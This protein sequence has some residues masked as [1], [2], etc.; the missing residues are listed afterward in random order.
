[1]RVS[2]SR[3]MLTA[4]LFA[5]HPAFAE[6]AAEEATTLTPVAVTGE[7]EASL[8]YLETDAG[9]A[10]KT[11]TPII[12]TP[13]S[14]SVI[15]ADLLRDR[16]ALSLQDA[17][18]Y[19][20]GVMS[21]AYGLD[22]RTDSAI[23]RGTE[24]QSVLDG[25][26]D[27]FN[28]YNTTRPDPYAYERVE[29]LRGPA[30]VLYGQGPSAG[31]VALVS[32][33]PLATAAN[34]VVAEYGRFDRRRLNLDSTGPLDREGAWL[35]RVVGAVQRSDSQVDYAFYDREMLMPSISWTPS[36]RLSWTL[37]A[38]YQ[39]DDSRNAISFL[40][41][42]GSLLPNPNGRIPVS[43]FTSEPDFDRFE[44]TRHAASSFI[45]WQL[46]E[47]WSLQQNLR[48]ADNHNPY[49]SIYPDVFSDPSDPFLDDDDR[50]VGRYVYADRRDQKDLTTDHQARAEFATGTVM[51]RLL[52]GVDHAR[53]RFTRQTGYGYIDTPFDLFAPDYGT[54]VEMPALSDPLTTRARYTGVYAQDQARIGNW[55]AVAGIRHDRSHVQPDGG[56][57]AK[58]SDTTGRAGLMYQTAIGLA[59][60]VSWSSSFQPNTDVDPA[61]GEVFDPLRGEQIEF[62]LKFQPADHDTLLTLTW[63]NLAEDNRVFYDLASFE[64]S[65]SDVKS[66]GVEFEGITRVGDLDLTASYTYIDIDQRRQY[67]AVQPRH[68]ASLW[69]KYDWRGLQI[70][71]GTRYLGSTTDDG[72]TLRLPAVLLFDA[73]L[74]W[75]RAQWRVAVNATNLEDQTYVTSCL[76]RGDCFYGNRGNIVGSL[77][78]RF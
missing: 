38:H 74:A 54:P 43:R 68:L 13:A 47:V 52:L 60:Y 23:L 78:Y 27:Q 72:G 59:P 70:G 21:D 45:E 18:R 69:A 40:P 26:R 14:V 50:T 30:S 6:P 75:E 24:F 19:S 65:V 57:A 36:D 28:Y 17:L 76:Q 1:M 71:A 2:S 58:Q 41:H 7:R 61:T 16:G 5:G 8:P 53:S 35:Y 62:G 42:S 49:T 77:R 29:I 31:I 73:M 64:P 33:R 51:H 32:K 9:T 66:R 15:T 67:F 12:E 55:I 34:E 20:A 11:G 63:F 56:D 3:L 39:R 25:M 22:N 44:A 37:L 48:F 4:L 10:T 46:S